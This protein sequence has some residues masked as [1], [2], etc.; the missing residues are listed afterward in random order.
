MIPGGN[1]I[2]EYRKMKIED[3]IEWCKANNQVAWLKDKV[4]EVKKDKDGNDRAITFVEIKREFCEKFMPDILPV[5][6]K[7]K[8]MI[9]LID[10]L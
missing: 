7:K 8:S 9:E 5:A 6:N 2:M 3:I 1:I 4:H 10:A